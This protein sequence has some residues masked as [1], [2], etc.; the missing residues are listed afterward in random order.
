[1][2]ENWASGCP[3]GHGTIITQD[4]PEDTAI[5]PNGDINTLFAN[6]FPNPPSTTGQGDQERQY[7]QQWAIIDKQKRRNVKINT[8]KAL[9]PKI[10]EFKAYLEAVYKDTYHLVKSWEGMR[11]H[12]LSSQ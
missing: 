10:E 3:E 4:G 9:N 11:L 5:S 2:D 8:E 12:V 7:Y 6:N 1:M